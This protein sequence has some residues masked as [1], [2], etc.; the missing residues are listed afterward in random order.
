MA[1]AYLV[2]T[3]HHDIAYLRPEKEYTARCLQIIDEAIRIMEENPE[4]HFF[5]EQAWLWEEYWQARPDK[6]DAMRKLAKEGRLTLEPGMYAVPDMTLPDGESLYMQVTL[7]KKIAKETLGYDPRVCMITDCWGHHGQLPQIMT[8][9]GYDY[10]AFSRCMRPDVDVQNFVWK[11]VDGSKLRSHWMSTHYDGIG[12]PVEG[13]IE[14]A[15]ELNWEDASE[16]GISKLMDRNRVKCGDDPQYLPVGGDMRYPSALA[17]KI[18]RN[19]NERGKL[20]E[21][22]FVAPGEALDA[23]DWASKPEFDGEF[24]SD[25]QGS[26]V[27]N[28]WIKLA[29]RYFAREIYTLEALSAAL[30]AKKDF[31]LAW[32]LHLKNQFHDIIC[33]T[34]CNRAYRDVEADFRTLGHLLTQ[35]RRELTSEAGRMAY[36]NALP[37]ERHIRTNEGL[38]TVPAMGFAYADEAVKPQKSEAVL[39]LTFDN[40]WYTAQIDKKGYITSIVEKQTGRE[41]VSETDANGRPVPFGALNMQMD[42]GDSWLSLTRLALQHVQQGHAN[43]PPDPLFRSDLA[44]Y[45]PRILEAKVE[46]ADEDTI[47][48]K[49]KGVIAFWITKVQ[50]T[51]TI[52]L[53]KSAREIKYHTEFTSESKT[54]RVRVAFPVK[55]MTERRR[56]IPYAIMPFGEGE[57]TVQMFMDTQNEQAG[58]AVI[59]TGTPSGTIEDGVMLINMFRSVAMEYKCDSDLSY[60][61]GREFA[62]DYAVCPH[63]N[64]ED[65]QIW[66]TAQSLNVP[67]I[68][69]RMP[70]QD[71]GVKVDGAFVSAVRETENGVFVR[72]YNPLAE[73]KVCRLTLPEGCKEAIFADGLGEVCADAQAMVGPE[74]TLTLDA[75]K[76]Q[77][78][79]C[80]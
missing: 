48:I 32:K 80:R 27:T 44:T 38:L 45:L 62:F 15:D 4:Y 11:G 68:D 61:L 20:P 24:M 47:V 55:D 74:I 3:F 60:N 49:Q 30:G 39:P 46:S 56:Q 59:N 29:D 26:F 52:T 33:G 13:E 43:N 77:G 16:A 41:L 23:I 8:Q 1:T 31:T 72:L 40:A 58:L 67:V 73:A 10:Y 35:I 63:A 76:V 34:I 51:T 14:N 28:I 54:I 2:P 6:R 12:F 78:I 64:G 79:L 65:E 7:G 25:M 50:F 37:Y 75:Y 71:K 57:Q 69:C 17:P 66:K 5:V 21:L 19:L 22:K 53:S 9:C 18:V 70:A 36:F 42:A